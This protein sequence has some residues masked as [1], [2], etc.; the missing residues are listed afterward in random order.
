MK[1]PTVARISALAAFAALSAACGTASDVGSSGVPPTE[2]TPVPAAYPEGIYAANYSGTASGDGSPESPVKSINAAI[3]LAQSRGLKDVFVVGGGLDGGYAEV[4]VLADGI[5]LHGAVCLPNNPPLRT[6]VEACKTTINGGS[7]T[8]VGRGIT[9]NTLVERFEILGT[10]GVQTGS[11]QTDYFDV[12]GVGCIG[13][14]VMNAKLSAC[15][16]KLE[17]EFGRPMPQ[18]SVGVAIATSESIFF[19]DVKIESAKGADGID[20]IDGSMGTAGVAGMPGESAGTRRY[21][22]GRGG[23]GGVNP[24]C[25]EAAGGKGGRGGRFDWD[26]VTWCTRNIF[27]GTITCS[28]FDDSM[29]PDG[30]ESVT[31]RTRKLEENKGYGGW[32]GEQSVLGTPAGAGH[33]WSFS[34]QKGGDGSNGSNGANGDAGLAGNGGDATVDLVTLVSRSGEQGAKGKAGAGG[35]GGGGGAPGTRTYAKS[36]NTQGGW[37]ILSYGGA[38]GSSGTSYET[39]V[40]E[41]AGGAGS[42]GAAGGCGGEG[43]FGGQGGAASVAL[44]LVDA[45][46]DF[47]TS[48]VQAGQ[49]G[50]GGEGGLGGE[51]GVGGG[52]TNGGNGAYRTPMNATG[53]W[54]VN[55]GAASF[56]FGAASSA[57]ITARSASQ[58]GTGGR[59]GSGGEGGQGGVGGGG[60]GGATI[61]VMLKGASFAIA[62]SETTTFLVGTPGEGGGPEEA[63]GE[64]GAAAPKYTIAAQ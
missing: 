4:V 46:V 55:A 50:K 26:G 37:S 9:S 27:T 52:V 2:V 33:D 29:D 57:G 21:H 64:A 63:K 34:K 54:S 7:P 60:A 32:I 30:L 25:P 56:I 31:A 39:E 36:T 6:D 53:S 11:A 20:G 51:G 62:D 61:S 15:E 12:P 13:R 43:G 23:R 10:P 45:T 48:T 47:T 40:G 49:G 1:S 14:G 19:R 5:N 17:D 42:G 22:S 58:G 41:T 28:A 18:S 44:Y 3:S 35:G 59:G 24:A 8:M 38:S 16:P